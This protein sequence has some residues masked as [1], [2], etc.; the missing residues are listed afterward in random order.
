MCFRFGGG[1]ACNN[2]FK[3]STCQREYEQLK[4]RQKEE[5]ESFITVRVTV[6]DHH[7]ED[8]YTMDSQ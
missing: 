5:I 7:N 8:M 2:L 6:L 1:P 3:C 4:Q